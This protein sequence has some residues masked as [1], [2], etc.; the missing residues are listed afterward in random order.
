M[1]GIEFRAMYISDALFL[2]Y[3]PRP[4]NLVFGL[5]LV[6]AVFLILSCDL[7]FSS[8]QFVYKSY[9][10]NSDFVP[11]LVKVPKNSFSDLTR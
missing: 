1:L 11:A 5:G 7:F 9:L 8:F 3:I 4:T 10:C 2:S 6:K